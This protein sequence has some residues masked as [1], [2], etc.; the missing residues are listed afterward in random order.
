MA[1]TP[2]DEPE[3]S[4]SREMAGGHGKS[5][6]TQ[7]PRSCTVDLRLSWVRKRTRAHRAVLHLLR[8]HV[9]WLSTV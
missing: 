4:K 3:T 5:P 6:F 8:R 1:N 9:Q 7:A 2:D